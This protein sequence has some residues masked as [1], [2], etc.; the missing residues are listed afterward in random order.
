MAMHAAVGGCG[1]GQ[2]SSGVPTSS[3][4]LLPT[5]AA[6]TTTTLPAT[7]T[8]P[9]SAASLG[10]ALLTAA[11][12]PGATPTPA[13]PGDLDLSPCFPGN[14]LGA[15]VDPSEVDGPDLELVQGRIQ[16]EYSSRARQSTPE[17]AA[18]FVATVG[19]PA[20]SACVLNALKASI[21]SDPPPPRIDAAGLAGVVTPVDIGE[22]AALVALNGSLTSDGAPT[23]AGFELLA[24]RKG[25]VVVVLLASAVQG[26]SLPGQAI[27]LALSIARR[28][29]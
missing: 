7:T 28:L 10:A 1:G 23:P 22:G 24:F 21:G 18:A 3:S 6:S 19:S 26:P 13:T 14:P 2:P 25:P 12:V 5:T 15:R 20:G 16:R 9:R 27:G 4:S 17:Q 29:T 8:S 11:D